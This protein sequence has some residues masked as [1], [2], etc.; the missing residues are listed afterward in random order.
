MDADQFRAGGLAVTEEL[1][2]LAAPAP[3][4]RVLDAGSGLGGP[5][6]H[7]AEQWQ[8]EVSGIDLSPTCVTVAQRLASRTALAGRVRDVEGSI[9]ELPF[10]DGHFD[11]VWTQHVVMNVAERVALYREF[12]RVLTA[13]GRLAF[14]DPAAADAG[15]E[16]HLQVPRATEPGSS[17]LLTLAHMRHAL[18]QAGFD[19]IAIDEL[20]ERV[21]ALPGRQLAAGA[22]V[23][24]P[25]LAMILGPGVA[26][27]VRSFARNL[28]EGRVRLL[29][30]VAEAR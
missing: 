21:G 23:V 3:G 2:R 30:G 12:R 8:A 24:G 6:R 29:M 15:P 25:S 19:E 13:G 11:L 18:A 9:T 27:S 17:H 7:L 14:F 4:A 10:A 26:V 5:S 16:P 20:S 28:Q 1:A 22:P